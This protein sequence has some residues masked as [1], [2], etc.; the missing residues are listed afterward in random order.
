M[1]CDVFT[2][3][4]LKKDDCILRWYALKLTSFEPIISTLII[5]DGD[6]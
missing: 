3:T 6:H 1:L 2:C 5:C 4:Q